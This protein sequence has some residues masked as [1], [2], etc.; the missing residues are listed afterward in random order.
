MAGG[1][2][3]SHLFAFSVG[4]W[5]TSVSHAWAF[6]LSAAAFSLGAF[7][8]PRDPQLPPRIPE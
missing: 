4:E 5:L 1:G 6:G 3:Q 2:Y 8:P 7:V